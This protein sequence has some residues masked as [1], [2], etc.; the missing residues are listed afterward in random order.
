MMLGE[1]RDNAWKMEAKLKRRFVHEG[2]TVMQVLEENRRKKA[3]LPWGA[4]NFIVL[5]LISML[6]SRVDAFTA[7]G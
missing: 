6:G 4:N 5:G 2:T 1:I 7:H 3:K